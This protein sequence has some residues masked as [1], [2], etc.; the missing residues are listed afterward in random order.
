MPPIWEKYMQQPDKQLKALDRAEFIAKL[1]SALE[2]AALLGKQ[3]TQA[4]GASDS[5]VPH[6][7]FSSTEERLA[8]GN[9]QSAELVQLAF[10]LNPVV[11]LDEL[12]KE[13]P[14]DQ[15]SQDLSRQCLANA[16]ASEPSP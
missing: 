14:T 7:T 3:V 9:A 12:E 10:K 1:D 2:L 16:M 13:L 4:F 6:R 15:L 5:T 8:A 11:A